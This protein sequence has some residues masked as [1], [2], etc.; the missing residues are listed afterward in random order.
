MWAGIDNMRNQK[1]REEQSFKKHFFYYLIFSCVILWSCFYKNKKMSTFAEREE[2]ERLE[3]RMLEEERE[4]MLNE[5]RRERER[6]YELVRLQEAIRRSE[7]E[8]RP[9]GD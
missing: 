4:R 2:M 5:Q 1:H 3:R 8:R 7:N 9:H 6:E